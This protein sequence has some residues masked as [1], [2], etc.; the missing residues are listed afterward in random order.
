ML[1]IV[2]LDCSYQ[3][4]SGIAS[5]NNRNFSLLGFTALKCELILCMS[6]V[7]GVIAAYEVEVGIGVEETVTDN[8]T[9][10]YHCE[11]IEDK[12]SFPNSSCLLI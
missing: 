11:M 4:S 5:H 3:T 1:W 8:S 6:P 7:S 2:K 9:Y 12:Q 10:S